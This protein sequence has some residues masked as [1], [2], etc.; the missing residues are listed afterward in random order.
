MLSVEHQPHGHS[1]YRG[2]LFTAAE[3]EWIKSKETLS[4]RIQEGQRRADLRQPTVRFDVTTHY[5]TRGSPPSFLQFGMEVSSSADGGK[6]EGTN[7]YQSSCC[8]TWMQV[9]ALR[10]V[11][12]LEML[13]Y[14]HTSQGTRRF[15][16]RSHA[17]LLLCG[18]ISS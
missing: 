8:F 12:G 9:V 5:S 1:D 18:S 11:Y 17:S 16:Q 2:T 7:R 4:R 3:W 10:I 14:A 6:S 15:N 13:L